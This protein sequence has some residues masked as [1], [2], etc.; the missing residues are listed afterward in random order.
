MVLSDMHTG[1]TIFVYTCAVSTGLVTRFSS[2]GSNRVT[3]VAAS[4]ARRPTGMVTLVRRRLF[5]CSYRVA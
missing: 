2:H 4:P 5:P 1:L 3:A